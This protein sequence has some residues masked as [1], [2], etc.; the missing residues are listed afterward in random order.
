[1]TNAKSRTNLSKGNVTCWKGRPKRLPKRT[2][3]YWEEFVDPDTWYRNE[4]T[5]DV[6]KEEMYAACFDDNFD[7][8]KHGEDEANPIEKDSDFLLHTSDDSDSHSSDSDD[9]DSHSSDSDDS[10]SHS[11]DSDD[12][13]SRSSDSDDSN[14]S[15]SST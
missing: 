8:E 3:S 15:F 4:I 5:K 14:S 12:S 6:P 2:V 10:N 7:D 1:M 13:D 11:S 9:S